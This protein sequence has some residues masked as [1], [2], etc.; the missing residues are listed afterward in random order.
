MTDYRVVPAELRNNVKHLDAAENAWAAAKKA[1]GEQ[2]LEAS[3]VGLLGH[4]SPMIEAHNNALARCLEILEKGRTSLDSAGTA[5]N[6]VA[7]FYEQQE[8]EYY[9]KFGYTNFTR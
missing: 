9:K 6:S 5:L 7:T 4:L 2:T 8:Y 3:D 1:L